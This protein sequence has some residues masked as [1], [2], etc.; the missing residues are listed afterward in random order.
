MKHRVYFRH[1]LY[2]PAVT[3]L[4]ATIAN[5]LARPDCDDITIIFSS[6]GGST[7]EGLALYNFIRTLKRPITMH[8]VGHVGSMGLPVFVAG[9]RRTCSPISRFFFHTYDWGFEGR[10]T[11]DRIAEATQ[12]LES[13]I[14]LSRSILERHTKIPAETLD[15]VYNRSTQPLIMSPEEAVRLGVVD[16]VVDL[17]PEGKVESDV[18]FWT[19]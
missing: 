10:Q 19:A 1:S 9:H 18:I 5:I 11:L 7:D 6:E 8:A 2:Q 15:T 12:R 17:N 14:K 4:T 3:T 13:D 16:E